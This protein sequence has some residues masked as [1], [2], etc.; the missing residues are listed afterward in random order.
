MHAHLLQSR[1]N[2]VAAGDEA[3][4]IAR[5]EFVGIGITS[6]EVCMQHNRL[7][8]EWAA[9]SMGTEESPVQLLE[10]K[11]PGQQPASAGGNECMLCSSGY[12]CTRALRLSSGLFRHGCSNSNHS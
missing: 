1:C 10:C 12:G 7:A 6:R 4:S 8:I 9:H 3:G 2:R 11:H 5:C